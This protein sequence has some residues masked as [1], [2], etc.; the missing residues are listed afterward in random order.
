MSTLMDA[1][2]KKRLVE[3]RKS[4]DL[5]T[6]FGE[7]KDELKKVSWTTRS[8]LLSATK[9]VVISVFCFGLGIYGVDFVVKGALELIKRGLLFIFGA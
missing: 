5:L 8:E 3:K 7:L 4:K 2:Q 1:K 6:F 9:I